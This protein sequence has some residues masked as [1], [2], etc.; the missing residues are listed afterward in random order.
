AAQ[1]RPPRPPGTAFQRV[2][3]EFR[4]KHGGTKGD[5]TPTPGDVLTY[6]GQ[7]FAFKALTWLTARHEGRKAKHAYFVWVSRCLDCGAEYT[8]RTPA[9]VSVARG[10]TRRCP[11]HVTGRRQRKSKT[12]AYEVGDYETPTQRVTRGFDVLAL[13]HDRIAKSEA[14]AFVAQHV[15][16]EAAM[17]GNMVANW[18]ARGTKLDGS[19]LPFK[20]DGDD[21]VF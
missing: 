19:P 18:E 21:L 4:E 9:P 13:V 16:I 15:G 1:S 17:V 11:E 20:F 3:A 8:T 10:I 7:E 14:I 2:Y 5:G 6:D 12:D